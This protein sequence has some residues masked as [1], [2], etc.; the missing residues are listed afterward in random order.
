MSEKYRTN[1]TLYTVSYDNFTTVLKYVEDHIKANPHLKME[2]YYFD[3][4]R[5][6]ENEREVLIKFRRDMTAEE[7]AEV[8]IRDQED[9]KRAKADRKAQYERLKKEFGDK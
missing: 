5:D 7:R 4:D 9:K 8:D 1:E 2:D 3:V 6:W